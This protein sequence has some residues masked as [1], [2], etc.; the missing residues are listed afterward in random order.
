MNT[1]HYPSIELCKKLTEIGFPTT[2]QHTWDSLWTVIWCLE[3]PE[4]MYVCP[5]VMEM[6]DVMPK[7]FVYEHKLFKRAYELEIKWN[8]YA[9]KYMVEYYCF[10]N[11]ECLINYTDNLPNALASMILWLHENSYLPK[12]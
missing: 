7:S 10:V 9:S 1:S 12:K 8:N 11:R 3:V 4:W 2:F 5:S 6:L